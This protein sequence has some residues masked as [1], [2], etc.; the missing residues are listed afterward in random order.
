MASL[1]REPQV[2]ETWNAD[3]SRLELLPFSDV[4][5]L[6]ISVDHDVYYS[7]YGI[8]LEKCVFCLNPSK[9]RPQFGDTLVK[10]PFQRTYGGDIARL[11]VHFACKFLKTRD[12]PGDTSLNYLF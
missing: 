7:V 9:Q 8:Q 11:Q 4:H 10:F 3:T 2:P 12:R 1:K 6:V 5:I